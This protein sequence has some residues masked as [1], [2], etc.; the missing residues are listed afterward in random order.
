MIRSQSYRHFKHSFSTA[1]ATWRN[2]HFPK[3]T[4][5]SR[6][7]LLIYDSTRAW[8]WS[9]FILKIVQC[10][11]AL[12]AFRKIYILLYRG[13]TC[14]F[15]L[16]SFLNPNIFHIYCDEVEWNLLIY[17]WAPSSGLFYLIDFFCRTKKIKKIYSTPQKPLIPVPHW[18]GLGLLLAQPDLPQLIIKTRLQGGNWPG[19]C[20]A[21]ELL[22]NAYLDSA[23]NKNNIY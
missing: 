9:R 18:R 6:I 22:K 21:A 17:S 15:S 4:A 3:S 7:S 12:Q 2:V 8:L 11:Q 1:D 13:S 5:N 16:L 20:Q 10:I 23:W 14:S 19:L